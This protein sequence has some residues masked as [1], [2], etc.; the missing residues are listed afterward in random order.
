MAILAVVPQDDAIQM[1]IGDNQAFYSGTV[2]IVN[3]SLDQLTERVLQF[4][5]DHTNDTLPKCVVVG[6]DQSQLL[7]PADCKKLSTKVGLPTILIPQEYT[8]AFLDEAHLTG[9]SAFTRSLRGPK[10][11]ITYTARLAAEELKLDPSQSSFVV[12][13]V[14]KTVSTA[15]VRAGRIIDMSSPYD[16]GPFSVFTSGGLPFAGL[17][18]L[19]KETPDQETALTEVTQKGG[20]AGYLGLESFND[21][22]EQ[23][24]SRHD[25]D[26]IYSAFVYQLAKEI[27]AY[28]AV[29]NGQISAVVLS[30][31]LLPA[32][33]LRGLSAYLGNVTLLN[34]P[35]DHALEAVLAYGKTMMESGKES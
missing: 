12:A 22:A 2:P 21:A 23:A 1:A 33:G 15:A 18:N 32:N 7:S 27:G 11:S 31:P 10:L 26:L 9:F 16:E 29:L 6:N 35:G 34:F 19:I 5:H 17:L 20:F 14:G 8:D 3:Y 25:V 13:H 30:G 28:L 4:L 24:F